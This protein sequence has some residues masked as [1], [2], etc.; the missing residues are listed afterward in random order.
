MKLS[1]LI[2]TYNQERYIAQAL[3]SVL[4]QRTDFDFEIVVGDDGSTD[5][6]REI[7]RDYQGRYP[8]KIR[9]LLPENNTGA[10]RNFINTYRACRGQFVAILEGDD[11]WTSPGKLQ[12]QVDF[13]ESHPEF[14]LCFTNSRIVNENGEVIKESRLEED[15]RKNLTQIDII[16]GLVPPT[17]TVVFR[18][19]IVTEIPDI[20]YTAVNGDIMFFSMLAGHGNAAY[21]DEFTGDYRVHDSGTWSNKPAFYMLKNNLNARL[22]LLTCFPKYKDILLPF[23]N[24]Y[25]SELLLHYIRT[26]SLINIFLVAYR[27]FVTNL[28]F[29]NFGFLRIL[30]HIFLKIL[31]GKISTT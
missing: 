8:G 7:L 30:A 4:A 1:V 18:N 24:G 28:K 26:R 20:F 27:A 15:R 3:D 21:I 2:I 29:L 25:Y 5:K 13:L 14:A 31:S 23:V 12:L 6:T 17:N 10:T 19:N 11:Y 9:L 16:A 22:A